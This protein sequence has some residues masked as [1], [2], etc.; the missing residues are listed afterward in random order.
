MSTDEPN[1]DAPTDGESGPE[2]AAGPPASVWSDGAAVEP[3]EPAA[4]T[5]AVEPSGAWRW[6]SR[7]GAPAWVNGAIWRVVVAVICISSPNKRAVLAGH[8]RRHSPKLAK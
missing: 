8:H 5:P 3:V 7:E 4:L 6:M 2:A 1:D